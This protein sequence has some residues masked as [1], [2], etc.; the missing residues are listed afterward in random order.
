MRSIRVAQLEEV[1][2]LEQLMLLS[3]TELG[4]EDYSETEIKS[5]NT[6]VY[7][8]DTDLIKDQTYYVV[9]VDGQLAGCGGWSKR[10]KLYGGTQV[11]DFDKEPIYSDPKTDAAKIRAF[12]VHPKFARQGLGT[13]LLNH[14]EQEAWLQGYDRFEMMATL[15]GVKLYSQRNYRKVEDFM[16]ILPDGNRLVCVKMVKDLKEMA[17]GLSNQA[18]RLFEAPKL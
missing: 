18:P 12:F 10:N 15:P 7:G 16:K 11:S 9:E 8:I 13:L 17:V 5:A 6:Y 2:A 3:T 14:C 4:K 1:P